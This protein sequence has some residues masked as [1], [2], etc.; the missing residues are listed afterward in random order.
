MNFRHLRTFVAIVDAGGVARA[1]TRLNMTQP[2]ASRQIDALETE[3]GVLL[4]DR[5][6]RRVQ[7]TSE[8]E[9]LLVRGRKLLADV[10]SFRERARALKAGQSGLL[11]VGATPQ[12]IESVLVDFLAQ[13]RPRHPGVEIHLV[14]D[15]GARLPSRLERGD[16]HLLIVQDG[17][18]PYHKRQLYPIYMM[19]VMP[20]NHRLS[21]RA[22]LDIKELV[23][24]P[25]LLLGRA[26]ASREWFYAACQV[27]HIRPRVFLESAA[28]QTLIALAAGAYGI[29]VIPSTVLIPR[30]KIRAVPLV[31]RGAP[32]GRWLTI[33]WN[34]QRFLAPYAEQFVD[35]MVVY[36]RRNFPNR[37]LAPRAPMLPKQV[38]RS[39][40]LGRAKTP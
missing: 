32:I 38:S 11:R 8:G 37:D 12:S 13:Y 40:G 6:G 34:P 33:A 7:L 21:R 5:I 29:A 17:D 9:D 25:L 39:K 2:T 24:E 15:G 20:Q 1:A 30:G 36:T 31:Y 22:V 4:F 26:F 35:E 14:E 18:E 3:L 28:P 19:A 16:V 10:A 27:A 23:D